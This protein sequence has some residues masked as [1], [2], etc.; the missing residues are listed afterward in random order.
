MHKYQDTR[1]FLGDTCASAHVALLFGLYTLTLLLVTTQTE[2]SWLHADPILNIFPRAVTLWGIPALSVLTFL[3]WVR[4]EPLARQAIPS[5]LRSALFGA[6][7]AIAVLLAVRWVVGAHL[8]T[9]IPPEE[10]AK[11]GYLLGMSAGLAEELV[12]RLILT[13]LVFVC[14]RR[15]LGFHR[16][17]LVTVTIVALSFALWHEVGS[18]AE[19][20]VLQHFATRFMVPGVI[21]GLAVFYISPIFVV[22]LHC[23]A[24]I[25]IPLLFV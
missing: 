3:V 6:L 11:P 14:L 22:A 19:P 20:F 21:M 9:F 4:L 2:A 16:S 7:A 24:H 25:M 5:S 13:P 10:S 15:W 1:G 18:G 8:P 17:V 23:T 12:I